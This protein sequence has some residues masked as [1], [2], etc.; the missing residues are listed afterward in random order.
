M[1][2]HLGVGGSGR[3]HLGDARCGLS[4]SPRRPCGLRAR[5]RSARGLRST[6]VRRCRRHGVGGLRQA[7]ISSKRA[8]RS[9][10]C[11]VR[12]APRLLRRSRR[13]STECCSGASSEPDLRAVFIAA[14]LPREPPLGDLRLRGLSAVHRCGW[15]V[16]GTPRSTRTEP[17]PARDAPR[18]AAHVQYHGQRFF[19]ATASSG[20]PRR[21]W[22]YSSNGDH[23]RSVRRR[24]HPGNLR[25]DRR[26]F[27]SSAR[28]H[29]PSSACGRSTSCS[30]G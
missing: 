29:S 20:T 1:T 16:T 7:A 23:R 19:C 28:T 18:R 26:R 13:T 17:D 10:T 9:T 8:C 11:R 3:S 25:R 22:P 27:S 2:S 15:P 30:P 4:C 6:R 12:P 21:C 5:P 14:G 24:L